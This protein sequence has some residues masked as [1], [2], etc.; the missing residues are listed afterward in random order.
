MSAAAIAIAAFA[1]SSP[2]AAAS[3][4]NAD[5]AAVVRRSMAQHHLRA[6]IVQVRID[7]TNAYTA[8]YGDSM[9]GVPATTHMHFRNGALAFTYMSTLLLELVDRK[10]TSLNARLSTYFPSLPNANGVTLKELAQM[11]SG[12]ADYVYQPELGDAMNRDPFRRWSTD[13]LIRIGDSNPMQFRPGSNWGYSH[14]N[15]AILGR[16]LEKIA[17]M[18]LAGALKRYVLQPMGLQQTHVS[19]TPAI[20]E[21]VLHTFT[22]ERRA[23]LGIKPGVPFFEEATFWDPSWTTVEGAVETT[24]ID[25]LN[26]SMEAVAFGKLLSKASAAAQTTPTLIGFG[27]TQPNCAAC[28]A[29]TRSFNYGLGVII[30]GGWITQ[31]LGFA[32]ATGTVG[33][34]PSRHLCVAI[35]STNGPA[36]YDSKGNA[37]FGAVDVFRAVVEKIAPNT[38][39]AP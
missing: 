21:P 36:A 34:L 14:T 30:S 23:A 29:N 32:G 1:T 18:P 19:S 20:P 7:G 5:L 2:A 26:T 33:C 6:V 39:P 24:D 37:G 35:E 22:S 11:T 16:V 25:D 4:S 12:Y 15:Y 27:H 31:T 10:K 28:R 13:E 8:A 9:S 17:G 3:F 38:L